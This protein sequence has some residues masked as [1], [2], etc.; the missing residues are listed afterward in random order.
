MTRR[1]FIA[2][3]A[4]FF[5]GAVVSGY[6]GVTTLLGARESDPVTTVAELL[7]CGLLMVFIVR[8]FRFVGRQGLDR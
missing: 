6:L 3:Q 4:A 5:G 8:G 1:S 2:M 7:L